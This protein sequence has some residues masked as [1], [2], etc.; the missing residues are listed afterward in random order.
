MGV[1][2]ICGLFGNKF[3]VGYVDDMTYE[4]HY[5]KLYASTKLFKILIIPGKEVHSL[6]MRSGAGIC[7]G[8]REVWDIE[9]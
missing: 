7:S 2:R 6:N 1:I 3:Y 8:Y 9:Y 5:K 4:N